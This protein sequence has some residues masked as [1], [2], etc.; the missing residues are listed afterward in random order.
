MSRLVAPLPLLLLAA[1]LAL[2]SGGRAAEPS[3]PGAAAGP[4]AESVVP[5]ELEARVLRLTKELRCLV[6]QGESVADSSSDFAADVRRKVVELMEQGL[7]DR[8]I[9][10]YLVQRYGEFI[11]FRPPFK[12][13][14]LFLWVGPILLLLAGGTALLVS[15]RRRR[16]RLQA[17]AAPLSP[18]EEARVRA[19]L[20]TAGEK[21]GQRS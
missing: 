1:A 6:C 16:T 14:T 21:R 19:L 8:E 18:E 20:E 12:A 9:K 7:T 3:E 4:R 10:D 5:P 15:I 17:E 13:T 11:L 2:A